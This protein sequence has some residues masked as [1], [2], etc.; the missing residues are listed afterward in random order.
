MFRYMAALTAPANIDA[1][2]RALDKMRPRFPTFYMRL[3]SGIFWHY[4]EQTDT[5]AAVETDTLYPCPPAFAGELPFRIKAYRNRIAGEFSHL[6][7]D[8][9]G[10]MKFFS[11]LLA[12]Y[13]REQ[14][15][16]V[17]TGGNIL[18]LDEAPDPEEKEN[19]FPRFARQGARVTRSETRAYK[20]RGTALMPGMCCVTTGRLSVAAVLDKAHAYKVSIT[21]YLTATLVY[22]LY[23]LQKADHPQG[24]LKP[25][26]VSVPVNLRKY[27]PS[28][29]LRN[30][31]QYL[32]PGID[33]SLG[34]FTFQ[35]TLAQT[36][37][38]FHFMFTEKN[39][40]AR[41]SINVNAENNPVLR[42]IPLFIKRLGI[43]L[44]YELT[45]ET[46]YTSVLSNVGAL[47]LPD[48]I[49]PFVTRCDLMLKT[50]RR[51]AVECGVL[52][53]DDALSITFTRV[54]AEPYVERMFFRKLVQD[55]L[56]V[57]V[58]SNQL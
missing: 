12:Q 55:G 13:Y 26:K 50:A 37:H 27:Y 49:R 14:G 38:Y 17:P 18:A 29:T 46:A 33:P 21:E 20:V 22:V 5:A 48:E 45:G 47:E 44:V 16:A 3:R 51:N 41:L 19:A 35:E 8:G 39:L 24:M 43:R 4:L 15:I 1:L 36:H 25:V 54:I 30:F 34:D 11:T 2:Q 40:N 32:N 7:C 57:F 42:V 58:E 53:C 6:I 23:E 52:S 31:S 9:G 28:K 10:A 56:H